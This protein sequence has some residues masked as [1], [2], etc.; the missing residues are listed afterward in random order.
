MLNF[1]ALLILIPSLI[2]PANCS[3]SRTSVKNATNQS[4]KISLI[5]WRWNEIGE[6]FVLVTFVL[7]GAFVKIIYHNSRWL[8]T[9]IPESCVFIILGAILGLVIHFT[10]LK[11]NI[12][13]PSFTP[14]KFFIIY[15]PPIILESA[16]ALHDRVFYNNL[17]TILLFA[18]IG[19]IINTLMIGGSLLFCSKIG[20]YQ[21][22]DLTAIECYI[23]A[24]IIA[25]VDPVAV[26]AIFQEVNVDKA[27]YFLV[28]GE[29]L[30]ND[31]VVITIYNALIAL[32]TSDELKMDHILMS[33]ASF[34]AVS[35]GGVL[36]GIFY[37]TFTSII[38]RCTN[39][40]RV[41]EPLVVILCAY[42][43]YFS[44]E[45][46]HFS[47]IISLICC[48]LVQAAYANY[49]VSEESNTTI[50]Y[51]VKTLSS[52][53]DV[54]IF[55]FLGM[56][57]IED[58]HIWNSNFIVTTLIFCILYRFFSVF[59]LTY[60]A[61][62]WFNRLRSITRQEQFI[63]AFGGLRGAVAFALSLMLDATF[64]P[65]VDLFVTA[66]LVTIVFTVFVQGATTKPI[67]QLLG[68]QM[69]TSK[70]GS[71]FVDINL[72]IVE[73]TMKGIEEIINQPTIF[74][75]I[76]KIIENFNDR[77][78]RKILTQNRSNR[79]ALINKTMNKIKQ[80][81]EQKIFTI[82]ATFPIKDINSNIRRKSDSGLSEFS[83]GLAS[84]H[85][86]GIK[87]HTLSSIRRMSEISIPMRTRF[88]TDSNIEDFRESLNTALGKTS[89]YRL[90]KIRN[91]D[92]MHQKEN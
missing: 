23:F 82:L 9:Q 73:S 72:K 10:S 3:N 26:I 64:I 29:S 69:D 71:L 7:M 47:G 4:T 66:T 60:V 49:N 70:K 16:Y 34:I 85:K 1:C 84:K 86:F 59:L 80:S 75:I 91:L 65:S 48:G 35:G 39:K 81:K 14:E 36:I 51:L 89:Y 19:T 38:T 41:I 56:L 11:S 79:W 58:I 28:F 42:T 13:I 92:L 27:L 33:S 37:G 83:N 20:L 76:R 77:Y 50:K 24:T 15:L 61:N 32:S 54:T 17:G 44:A 78:I 68:L 57:L 8:N 21:P 88:S 87:R 5:G 62:H 74:S 90:P 53:S 63:M 45:L 40:V 55:L 25:A 46:F 31:A 12:Y 30:F 2:V 22:F 43:S 18:V 67:V 6:Y 52:I